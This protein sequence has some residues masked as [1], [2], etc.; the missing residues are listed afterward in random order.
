MK[1]EEEK[2]KGFIHFKFD[3]YRCGSDD[4]ILNYE[5]GLEEYGIGKL[6]ENQYISALIF[7]EDD[8]EKMYKDFINSISIQ[9]LNELC[10]IGAIDF[11]WI[12]KDILT[13]ETIVSYK[14]IW[15]IY[16]L[17]IVTDT[18]NKFENNITDIGRVFMKKRGI[19]DRI[20]KSKKCMI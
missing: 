9:D 1:D 4:E 8:K 20:M 7:E 16:R 10:D 17:V 6:D 15:D 14:R 5:I 19:R 11:N 13:F 18:K 12:K 2:Y 3:P